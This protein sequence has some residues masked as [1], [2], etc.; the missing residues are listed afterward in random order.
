MT[1]LTD[2][3]TDAIIAFLSPELEHRTP[4]PSW[5]EMA[6]EIIHLRNHI[7]DLQGELQR[8]TH[9]RHDTKLAALAAYNAAKEPKA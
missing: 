3:Q 9:A 7:A 2:E 8:A 4:L 1:R 6:M 5:D